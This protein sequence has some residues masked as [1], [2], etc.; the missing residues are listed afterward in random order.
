ME[1][2]GL[3][4]NLRIEEGKSV[5]FR[6]KDQ[7]I[8]TWLR[9]V[10]SVLELYVYR[11]C[12]MTRRFDDLISSAVVDWR[13]GQGHDAVTNELDVMATR[14]VIPIFVSC[15]TCDVKTE[16]L[17]ELAILRDRFGGKGSRAIIAPSGLAT[18]SRAPMRRRAEQLGIEVVEWDDLRMDRLVSRLRNTPMR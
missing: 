15:K 7:Q 8:R 13:A 2:I 14:G 17:N 5:S 11:D 10:G 6:F 4:E 9:D 1:E 18:K 3:I 16:A 12:L